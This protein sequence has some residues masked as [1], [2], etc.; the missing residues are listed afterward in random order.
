MCSKVTHHA[1]NAWLY[2]FVI[3]HLLHHT[4][5]RL[6]PFSAFHISQ[7]SVT[8][9][10]RRGEIFKHDFV[11]NLLLSPTVKKFRNRLIFSEVIG[12]SLVACFLTHSVVQFNELSEVKQPAD[13][14]IYCYCRPI[15]RQRVGLM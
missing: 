1:L 7:G 11:V 10:L 4:Y 13:V 5:F 12:K 14:Q 15:F 9:R 8:T 6:T 2:Y 3:Y